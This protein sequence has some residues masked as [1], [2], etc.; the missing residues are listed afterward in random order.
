[1]KKGNTTADNDKFQKTKRAYFKSL[2][3]SKL[4]LWVVFL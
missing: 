1:M 3:S 4:K 2:Y